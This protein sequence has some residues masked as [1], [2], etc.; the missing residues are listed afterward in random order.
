LEALET[1]QVPVIPAAVVIGGGIAGMQ[2]GLD[3]AQAGFQVS[4]VERTNQ[5]GGHLKQIGQT[6]PQLEPAADLAGELIQRVR[7]H[8]RIQVLTGTQVT[9]LGGFVGNFRLR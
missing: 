4:L 3:L 2:A 1:R 8:P 9:E 5:L 7:S 6:F